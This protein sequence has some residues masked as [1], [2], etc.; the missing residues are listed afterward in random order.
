MIPAI[1]DLI[2]CLDMTTLML[3]DIRVKEN[4]LENDK[5]KFLFSVEEVNKL[6][7]KGVPFRDAYR[8]V[9]EKIER[10]EF[11]P[12]RKVQHVHEGSIGN[13]M[14]KEITIR[15]EEQMG[16]FAKKFSEIEE[17]IGRMIGE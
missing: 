10:G 3:G 4:L 14:N 16:Y 9:G 1:A 6:V 12:D 13:L 8:Q 2:D 5:Y 17:V 7:L 15:M 11:D